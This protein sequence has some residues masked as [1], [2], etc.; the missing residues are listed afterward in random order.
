[1][2]KDAVMAMLRVQHFP[3]RFTVTA[4][5]RR[6]R[7]GETHGVDYLFVSDSEF[8]RMIVQD[9]LLEWALVH[10]NRY[11]VPREQVRESIQRGQ[12]ILMRVDVQGAAT[13]R[14]K[15][16]EA[17]LIFLAPP[18]ME[19]L[20]ERLTTRATETPEELATRITNAHEELK[21]LPEFDYLVINQND[22]L[23]DAVDKVKAII[24][25][26]KCRV[27]RRRVVV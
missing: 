14:S 7:Q 24:V 21:R 2:G 16:P 6:P 9:E 8:D 3:L 4:T 25:A 22:R 27:H 19:E 11:G 18:S 15:V 10:C 26:E 12:D 13:I 20:V 1:M 5:T 17:V 23:D